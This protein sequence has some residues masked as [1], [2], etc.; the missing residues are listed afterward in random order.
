LK[1]LDGPEFDPTKTFNQDDFRLRVQKYES[2][3]EPLAC[4]VGVLGR[5]GDDSELP[6][7]L[8]II[9]S[10]YR[11]SEKIGVGM[12]PYLNIRSYPAVLV[13]TAY[14]LGLTRRERWPA[15]HSLFT[16]AIAR[17][18]KEPRKVVEELFLWTWSGIEQKSWWNQ[19]DGTGLRRTP[20]SDHLLRI[21]EEWGKTFVGL[22][23]DFELM[24]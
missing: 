17:Q 2:I 4:M 22:S 19:I 3:T 15:L 16:A 11:H 8:D 12:K 20:L 14:G 24:F 18:H 7:V 21:F 23:P 6:L 13:F 5:W 9:N 10:L 1:E